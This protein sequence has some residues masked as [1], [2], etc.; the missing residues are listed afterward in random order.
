MTSTR[1]QWKDIKTAYHSA[2]EQGAIY[3]IRTTLEELED[4]A[5]GL[6]FVVQVAEALRDKPKPPKNRSAKT[7]WDLALW[8]WV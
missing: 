5:L 3:Q 7:K 2:E 4:K 1:A 6:P 8:L